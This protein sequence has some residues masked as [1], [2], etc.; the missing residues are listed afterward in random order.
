MGETSATNKIIARRANLSVCWYVWEA[1]CQTVFVTKI[2][3]Q[4]DLWRNYKQSPSVRVNILAMF[5]V[6]YKVLQWWSKNLIWFDSLDIST[7]HREAK[8]SYAP[9]AAGSVSH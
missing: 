8:E 9:A 5:N 4:E 3:F 7:C 6:Y 1:C 2:L